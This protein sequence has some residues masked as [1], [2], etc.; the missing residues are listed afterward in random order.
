MNDKKPISKEVY[1]HS[2]ISDYDVYLFKEGKHLRLYEKL[3]AH[4]LT[5]DGIDGIHFA[6]W[7]PNAEDVYVIGDFNSWNPTHNRLKIHNN[8]TGIWEGFIPGIENGSLYKYRV[9]FKGSSNHVEKTDPFA[10][11]CEKPPK[12]AS[13]VWDLN[14]KW[15]DKSWI[16][17]RKQSMYYSSPIS[18]YEVHLGSWKRNNG[19]YQYLGYKDLVTHLSNYVQRLGFTHIELLPVMEHPF[20]GSWGYQGSNYFAPTSRYGNPQDL[21][22]FIDYLHSKGIG[23]ILD[24]VPSHFAPDKYGL[25]YFDGSHLYEYEDQR[26]RVHP[27]WASYIFDLNKNEVRSFLLSNAFFWLDQYHVDGLRVDAVASMLYLDYSRRNGEW[28]PNRYGGRENLE[29]ISL[30]R[31]LNE[32]VNKFYPEVMVIAEESTAWPKVSGETKDGGLG[33]SMKWNM[34]WMHD[35]LDYIS[36]DPIYRRHHHN[37]LTFSSLYAFNE[38]FIL[39]LSHDEVVHGKGSLFRKMP[40]DNWQK[41]ANLRLLFGYM[42]GHPGKKLL[43]MGNEFGEINEWDHEKSINWRLLNQEI[44]KKLQIWVND[45]NNLYRNEPALHKFDFDSRGFEW[46]DIGDWTNSVISFIRKDLQSEDIILVVCNFTPVLRNSYRLGVPRSGVWNEILN[47][48]SNIYGGSNQGNL[49]RVETRN[50]PVHNRNQSIEINVPPLGVI[51]F[52]SKQSS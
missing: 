17:K 28:V 36:K 11:N 48:D 49:G 25:S 33:F 3:G 20:Y 24:W 42:Y 51:F 38:K 32:S 18:I 21:M 35:T 19:N 10:F 40:G 6:V 34:G 27:D 41:Y 13:V 47:S 4:H 22:Y 29:A 46:I 8:K 1:R 50:I 45:L 26:K 2:I 7:A 39:P 30:F 5:L 9:N 16:R 14:Y 52:K 43:F 12:T 37:Q 15:K 31:N 23:V 44:H